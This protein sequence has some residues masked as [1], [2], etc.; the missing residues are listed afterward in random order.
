MCKNFRGQ[1]QEVP[2]NEEGELWGQPEKTRRFLLF[3]VEHGETDLERARWDVI[4]VDF[5]WHMLAF[6]KV[7]RGY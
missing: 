7:L 2:K 6:Y 1:V 5:A 4:S 3:C